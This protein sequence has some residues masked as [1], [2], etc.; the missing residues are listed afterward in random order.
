MAAETSTLT[1]LERAIRQMDAVIGQ[2][3]PEQGSL[4]GTNE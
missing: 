1:L 2:V 3:R 4:P